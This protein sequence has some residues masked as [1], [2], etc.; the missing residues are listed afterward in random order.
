MAHKHDLL[1]FTGVLFGLVMHAG[2][3]RARG[4]NR[5]KITS[6][7][8]GVIL[9]RRT[10]R[11]END[12]GASRNVVNI[13]DCDGPFG[14]EV[15]YDVRIVDDLMLDVDGGAEA[16]QVLARRCLLHAQRRRRSHAG[17]RDIP[18]SSTSGSNVISGP[19]I[20]PAIVIS[21]GEDARAGAARKFFEVSPATCWRLL[22]A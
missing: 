12:H 4:V 16:L 13:L 10:M 14:L 6:F 1:A 9:R 3:K 21:D 11:G 19:I 7:G 8:A 15:G 18:P 17:W 20:S 22:R 2:N 5:L